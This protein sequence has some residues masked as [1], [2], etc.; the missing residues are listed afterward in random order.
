MSAPA[1]R[2]HLRPSPA[3]VIATTALHGGAVGALCGTRLEPELVVVLTACV[4]V[5]WWRD[6]RCTGLRRAPAAVR[7]VTVAGGRF[8][9]ARNDGSASGP[10]RLRSAWIL[11][12][13][14][15]VCLASVAWRRTVVIVPADALAPGAFRA[16]RI[17]TGEA[18]L[19]AQ[20]VADA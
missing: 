9:I 14:V 4:L 15:V 8:E 6:I 12:M 11:D 17:A 1:F 16:L 19:G 18:L 13:A 2:F 20:A 10:L 5:A 3:Y 7:E